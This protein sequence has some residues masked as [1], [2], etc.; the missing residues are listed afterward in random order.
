MR[1]LALVA[2]AAGACALLAGTSSAF[3]AHPQA[4]NTVKMTVTPNTGVKAGEKLHVKGTGA[5]KSTGYYC[6]VAAHN[7][8]G[9]HIQNTATLQMPKSTKTGTIACTLTFKPFSAKSGG[10]LRHCPT[11]RADRAAGW[12]CGAALADMLTQ[13]HKSTGFAKIS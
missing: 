10:H 11:T 6:I 7:K 2:G 12:V 13:G 3:A 5:L 8:T 9:A 4:V 1:K